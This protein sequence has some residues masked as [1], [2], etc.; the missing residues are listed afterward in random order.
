[1]THYHVTEVGRSPGGAVLY[2]V[3]CDG[4]PIAHPIPLLELGAIVEEVIEPGDTYQEE[5]HRRQSYAQYIAD[6]Q[7]LREFDTAETD[8]QVS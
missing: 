7:R 3:H 5:G 2:Q 6:R 1:M 8:Q 4:A